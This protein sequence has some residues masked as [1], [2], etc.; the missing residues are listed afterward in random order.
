MP[1]DTPEILHAGRHL[2]LAKRDGW[3][4]ATRPN[5]TGVVAVVAVT[6][7]GELVLVRQRRPVVGR[8]VLELPAGLVG[9]DRD[10]EEPR[11]AAA[12]R[13]L[14]EETG[15]AASSWRE[16]LTAYPSAGL[17]DEAVSFFHATGL[18]RTGAGGGVGNEDIAVE[19]V[20]LADLPRVLAEAAASGV[21]V[22]MKVPAGVGLLAK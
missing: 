19:R 9:D 15:Y 14:E 13:E 20:P 4:Y 22:D 17:T 8:E 3:E 6:D 16:L 21:G 11:L 5:A 10:A 18:T 2:H 7:D 1:E 12:K